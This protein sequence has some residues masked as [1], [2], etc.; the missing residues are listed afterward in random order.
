M[1][2]NTQTDLAFPERA[3]P[4]FFLLEVQGPFGRQTLWSYYV[5]LGILCKIIIS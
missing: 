3:V 5:M 2:I 4:F 1:N